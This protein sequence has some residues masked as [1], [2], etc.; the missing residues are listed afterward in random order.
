VILLGMDEVVARWV[1]QRIGAEIHPPFT[2]IGFVNDGKLTAGFVFS[3]YNGSNV[4]VTAATTRYVKKGELLAVCRYV[5]IQLGCRRVTFRA[6]ASNYRS[7]AFLQRRMTYEATLPHYYPDDHAEQYRL[8]R[9]DCPW[10]KDLTDEIS[11]ASSAA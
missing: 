2:A 9:E 10:L 3:D 8:L 11:E 1:S 4:E 6:K 5:F 7:T